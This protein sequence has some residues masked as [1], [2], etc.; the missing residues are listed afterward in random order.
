MSVD[1]QA[2]PNS[3]RH[4]CYR[5]RFNFDP[6]RKVIVHCVQGLLYRQSN[7][8]KQELSIFTGA[9]S[10][11]DNLRSILLARA[12]YVE[13]LVA[14]YGVNADRTSGYVYQEPRVC[15]LESTVSGMYY[16]PANTRIER[17]AKLG[18]NL[19]VI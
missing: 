17:G 9:M 14:I 6:L 11:G 3:L 8:L 2:H 19:A 1:P 5:L 12:A 7:S 13:L 16:L 4:L 15:L 18:R 10:I